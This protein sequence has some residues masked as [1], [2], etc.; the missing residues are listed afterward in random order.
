[1][2]IDKDTLTPDE[3]VWATVQRFLALPGSQ[4]PHSKYDTN[5]MVSLARLVKWSGLDGDVESGSAAYPPC[6]GSWRH[7][8]CVMG[9]H[10]LPWMVDRPQF[11]ANKFMNS[12]DPFS[13]FCLLRYLENK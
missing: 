5:E 1:M 2:L 7:G 9:I 13:T 11:F 3:H 4:P 12:A 10:D 6:R 8:I